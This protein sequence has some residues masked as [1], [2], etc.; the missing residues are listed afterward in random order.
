MASVGELPVGADGRVSEDGSLG[1]ASTT[2]GRGACD[3]IDPGAMSW[4]TLHLGKANYERV[5]NQT[6]HYAAGMDAELRVT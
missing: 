6:G 4:I 1:E 3:G 2:C 5:C